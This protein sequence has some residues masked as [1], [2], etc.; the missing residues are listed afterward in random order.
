MVI[1]LSKNRVKYSVF[2]ISDVQIYIL[3]YSN[4]VCTIG[5]KK[6]CFEQEIN[7]ETFGFV[8]NTPFQKT[9]NSTGWSKQ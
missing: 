5:N 8:D 9:I 6:W 7:S 4:N 2:K 3:Y 1:M